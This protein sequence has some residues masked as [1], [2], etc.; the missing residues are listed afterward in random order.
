MSL[1]YGDLE[2]LEKNILDCV[3]LFLDTTLKNEKAGCNKHAE[4]GI[5]YVV[6]LELSCGCCKEDRENHQPGKVGDL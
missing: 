5:D 1:I 3:Y 6:R 2:T 4:S